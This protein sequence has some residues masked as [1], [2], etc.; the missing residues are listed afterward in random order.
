MVALD[1]PGLVL[2]FGLVGVFASILVWFFRLFLLG[3]RDGWGPE[4]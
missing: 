1:S 4:R 2:V 3:T